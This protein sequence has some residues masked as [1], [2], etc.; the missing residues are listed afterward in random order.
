MY[1]EDKT[2]CSRNGIDRTTNDVRVPAA[3]FTFLA[4]FESVILQTSPK[5][6]RNARRPLLF[7]FN[8]AVAC[9]AVPRI[10]I[11]SV[12]IKLRN[13]SADTEVT[14]DRSILPQKFS[15]T[16]E[17]QSFTALCRKETLKCDKF[18]LKAVRVSSRF[19]LLFN[20]ILD[21]EPKRFI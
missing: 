1:I 17:F 14:R 2:V 20:R 5:L 19:P 4:R 16:S 9:N 7:P 11:R 18:R 10:S 12:K 15:W 3:I 13:Y 8:S 21:V 6:Y